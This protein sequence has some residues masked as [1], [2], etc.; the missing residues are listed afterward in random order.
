LLAPIPRRGR[1]SLMRIPEVDA[2]QRPFRILSLDGGGIRGAFTAG[3]LAGVEERIGHPVGRHFDLIA[4]TSTGGIIAAALAFGEPAER[5]EQF[6]LNHGPLIFSR[7][8]EKPTHFLKRPL[9][10]AFRLYPRA[11]DK[12]LYNRFSVDWHWLRNSKYRAE[13]LKT[14]LGAGTK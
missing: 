10:W 1:S 4:G 14:A 11:V 9:R 2:D 3:F 5:I 8:W 13:E 7:P 6:Y 12:A